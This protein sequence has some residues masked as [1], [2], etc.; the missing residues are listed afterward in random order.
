[1]TVT[2]TGDLP[3]EVYDVA[4]IGAGVV[5]TAIARELA[6]HRLRIALVEASD[7]VGDGT[8]KAN[9]AILHT[10]FDATPGTLEARLV[11]EG[12]Q[13]LNT[14]AAEAGIPVEPLGALLVAW[15]T[16]QLAALPA[17]AEKAVRNDCHDTRI[18]AADE[19][20]AREPHLGPGALG[21]L[22]VPGE[23]IICP[24]TTTLAYAT[25][26]V[27]GGVDLHLNCAAEA[28]TTYGH[29]EIATTRGPLRARYLVNAAGLYADEI[30]RRLGHTEFSVTPRRGQLIVFDKFA[31]GLVGHILLP[32]PTALGKGVLVAPTV[33]G[34]VMLGPT[35]E[36]LDDKHATGSTATGLSLL[37]DKGARIM[38]ELLDEEVTAVYAGLRAATEHAD[39]QIRAHPEQAYVA[40]GGI[41]STGLTA[42]M[43]IAAH[44]RDLLTD[45][46]LDP[47][48]ARDLAPP[49]MPNIGE[50]FARPYQRADLIAADPAYGTVVCHCERV[51]RGEIRDALRATV[52]P[53]SLDGLRRRT[54]ALGGR[55]QSFYCGAAVR[56]QF[57]EAG[58]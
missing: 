48:P 11:R 46:G 49:R 8:S 22:E 12:Y 37:R 40:V 31:R 58:R 17:L 30:D 18:L 51:T 2:T 27:R 20:Y 28:I 24:W 42:S 4:I 55:C 36:D 39:F 41:R 13:R 33:Y 1:M 15:D 21:A 29:H 7:D 53:G 52:P 44:V 56:A 3:G 14:Y 34:N 50:A 35:A 45:C 43:A 32:V 25:Q 47:G 10:G 16:E 57:E 38:P 19:V 9:T 26:A 6:A 5:G 23:S 54:R